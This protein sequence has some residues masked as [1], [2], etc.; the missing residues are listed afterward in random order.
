M[1]TPD[2]IMSVSFKLMA[3][4]TM[5]VDEVCRV[6]GDH[7]PRITNTTRV[8]IQ[9]KPEMHRILIEGFDEPSVQQAKRL[10]EEVLWPDATP[11]L[12]TVSSFPNPGPSG[13]RR[14][15]NGWA[16]PGTKFL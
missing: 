2:G 16:K 5:D 13:T 3:P 4:T 7:A 6:L 8:N 11:S 14:R 9:Y 10:L 15:K 12:G 1:T